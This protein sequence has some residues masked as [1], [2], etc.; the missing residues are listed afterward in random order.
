MIAV[1]APFFI[2][3][4]ADEQGNLG[5][6]PI[7]SSMA[8]T[9]RTTGSAQGPGETSD[10]LIVAGSHGLPATHARLQRVLE[11]A[12]EF[13]FW[14]LPTDVVLLREG[15][16]RDFESALVRR[17]ALSTQEM[18][19]VETEEAPRKGKWRSW[20]SKRP[21]STSASGLVL[22]GETHCPPS[23]LQ[24]LEKSYAPRGYRAVICC[25][26]QLAPVLS[27]F[28]AW[29][30]CLLD[31]P[32]LGHFS[33]LTH[34]RHGRRD[35]YAAYADWS[36][37]KSLLQSASALIVG[38]ALDALRLRKRGFPK[39]MI[40]LPPTGW[41]A[42]DTAVD[43]SESVHQGRSAEEDACIVAIG[44][45]T[46]ANVDGLR[47]FASEVMPRLR[48]R[49]PGA[50]LR[51]V[52]AAGEHVAES[53]A[54]QCVGRR[55]NL[56][57]EYRRAQV[58]ALP[59]RLGDGLRRR[60]VEALVR[61]KVLATTPT[62]ANG[63]PLTPGVDA[64]IEETPSA[65]ANQLGDVLLRAELRQQYQQRARFRAHEGFD[66]VGTFGML[67]RRL[68]LS[69]QVLQARAAARALAEVPEPTNG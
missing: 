54:V 30:D 48:R 16:L 68:G 43:E 55:D 13:S 53:D 10:I 19:L 7:Y 33:Y 23:L 27:L 52:G 49:V 40:L 32:R 28:P 21:P 69:R 61:G 41:V 50:V 8:S 63:I 5:A 45:A 66:P 39:D 62:G 42:D 64:I 38:C 31:V 6:L 34:E 57:P 9:F 59:L 44:V 11:L 22:G 36:R 51:I 35:E 56:E 65:M 4:Q 60:A 46:H 58:V 12:R 29:T 25:G 1:H 17:V 47:W 24:L 14:N 37:E 3:R 67:G 20:L 18:R 2:E 15:P 26:A